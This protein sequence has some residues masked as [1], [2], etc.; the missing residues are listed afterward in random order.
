MAESTSHEHANLA[1]GAKERTQVKARMPSRRAVIG[2]ITAAGAAILAD[3]AP[4]AAAAALSA[5]RL[6]TITRQLAQVMTSPELLQQLQKVRGAPPEQRLLEA[7]KRLSVDALR[8]AGIDL[9]SDMRVSSRYFESGW[10]AAIEFGD[11]YSG[12]K[13]NPVVQFLQ[14]SAGQAPIDLFDRDSYFWRLAMQHRLPGTGNLGAPV[15]G[16]MGFGACAGAGAA[17]VCGCAGA[18]T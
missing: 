17:T 2:A 13:P 1:V 10:P 18:S 5:D 4:S 9:P 15:S 12:Q 8:K 3:G 11:D 14:N 6:R 16:P 7:S